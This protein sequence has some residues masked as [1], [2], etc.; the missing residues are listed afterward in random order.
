M[1]G[2]HNSPRQRKTTSILL[3]L[4]LVNSVSFSCLPILHAPQFQ[5]YESIW[6]KLSTRNESIQTSVPISLSL[7][8]PLSYQVSQ[9]SNVCINSVPQ[10]SIQFTGWIKME[11]TKIART[12]RFFSQIHILVYV[13]KRFKFFLVDIQEE[14]RDAQ[15]VH[16][17]FFL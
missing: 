15:L 11:M 5:G 17:V 13:C 8:I 14:I 3:C 1:R 12:S 16:A 6:Q 10:H 4:D 9:D 7:S 2:C